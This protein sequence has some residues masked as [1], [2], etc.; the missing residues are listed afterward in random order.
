MSET[1]QRVVV[2]GAGTMGAAIAG[3]CANAGLRVT[4]LDIAPDSLTPD[5]EKKGLTLESRAVRDRIVRAGFERMAKSRPASLFSTTVAERIALGN[6][7]DDFAKVG[8]ADWIIE[9]VIE[10]VVAKRTLMARIEETRQPGSIV[11]SNTSGI[12]LHLI[13]AGRSEEF[14]RHFLGTHFFNPPRYM[15]LLE[16][17]PTADTDPAVVAQVRQVTEQMLGKGTV[18]CKDTPNFIANRIGTYSGMTGMRYALDNG[19]SIEE[20]DALTGP[21]I[22]R[23]KTA[24]FRL[25][26]LAGV[27]IMVD[28]AEN[29]YG[30]V[31]DDESRDEY[32]VPEPVK[33]MVAAGLRGNKTGAGFYKRVDGPGGTREFHVIA[34][35]TL[36]YHPPQ[37]PDIPLVKEAGA[38]RDLGE[39]LRFIME[40]ADTGERH[41]QLIEATIVPTLAYTA[42]RVPE[43]S[44]TIT[45]VDDAMRWG[46]A[47][48][49]GPFETWDLLGVAET[50][51]RMERR[52]IVVAPWVTEMLATGHPT[53]YRRENGQT[54]AYSPITKKYEPIP[55]DPHAIDLAALKAAG[56]EI[57]GSKGASLIDLGDGVL[58]F[59]VHTKANAVSQDAM[60]L[61]DHALTLLAD[62]DA[63]RAMV[64]GNQ[65]EYFSA[66]VDL[67]EIGGIAQA[68][69]SALAGLLES[70]H[71][72][73][74]RLRFSPKPVVA[75]PFGNTFG[76]GVELS[77]ASAGI[78]AEGETYMGL[79]EA[80][81]GLIPGGGGCKELV[82]RI[83]S[84]EM[85]VAGVNPLPFLSRI[86]ETIGQAKVST[87][88]IEARE[89][90]YLSNTDRIVLGRDRLLTEAK[91]MALDLADR[92]YQ[93]PL[94]GKQCYAAG[95]GALAAL[96]IGIY[97]YRAGG[98]V[99]VHDAAVLREIATVIC[100]GNLS[101]PQ[102][103]DEEYF[104]RL[105]REAFLRL[106]QN[107]KTQER[108][109]HT[110]QTGKPL[111]N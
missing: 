64:I 88:A 29:L 26:D 59:E 11:T 12:P 93:P 77:L 18:L 55:R 62:D 100:G 20:V 95:Q 65:G 90:G 109:A 23:P 83:V 99:S 54:E 16:I 92:G 71:Q 66:G 87:S 43:I 79:V 104:L 25:A 103:V 107:H 5:E 67:R 19:F 105:E 49:R 45:G 14:R 34:L 38:I 41:A 76:L 46:F 42:R 56:K 22:G 73:L 96:M 27:D 98:F 47:Q 53:F 102:W 57:A 2:L 74:Q 35:D 61:L 17:I 75:A 58:C 44:D 40:G 33:R 84:P 48:E 91:R 1:I 63:W 36:D 37:E 24:S 81:V 51:A 3:H 9:V 4:L 111:R 89:L 32:R 31:P 110:L 85:K 10:Q 101:A 6:F 21:L 13:V 52:G 72:L 86:L 108:I 7:V 60:Q 68:N 78:C 50:V 15:K 106:L 94:P 80:G 8:E 70:G 28:V 97:Q 82:R 30:L 69:P 39:R